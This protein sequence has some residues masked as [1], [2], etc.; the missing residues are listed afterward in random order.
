MNDNFNPVQAAKAQAKY[1][2]EHE[3]PEF[4]PSDGRC[5]HCGMNIYM[6]TNGP[7]GAVRGITVEKAASTLVTGCPHCNYS[8]VE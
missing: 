7:H 3:C 8:F 2:N 5:Y 4:A 1:C 6:P